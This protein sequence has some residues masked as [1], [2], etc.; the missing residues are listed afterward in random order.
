MRIVLPVHHFPP[1]YS[2]GA[3]LY[4]LRLARW[5]QSQGHDVEVVC[6]EA[7]DRG[8][9]TLSAAADTYDGITVWRLSFDM[10]ADPRLEYDNPLLG[11]WF[12]QYLDRR[13][14][15]LAHFQAGYL[16][17]AAPLE[18]AHAAGV[19][20]VL[21]LHDYWFLC[22]RITLLRGDGALCASVP[23][24][25]AECDWCMR[26]ASRRYRIADQLSAG[27]AGRA[28]MKLAGGP[29]RAQIADRRERLARALDLPDAVIAPSRFLAER[30]A[31]L[32]APERLVVSRLGL[33]PRPF[34]LLPQRPQGDGVLRIGYIGQ[35]APHKG[36]HL[37][38]EAF[39]RLR[40]VG[41]QIEL[42]IYGGLESNPAYVRWLRQLADGD[43][44]IQYH[45]RFENQRVAA[46]LARLDVMVTPSIWYENSP[47]TILESHAASVPVVTAALGGMAELVRHEVDGLHF[48]PA[49]AAD[50]ARQLQRA[51]DEPELLGRLRAGITP[52]RSL[53]D[54]GR[55]IESVYERL[56]A[57]SAGMLERVL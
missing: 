6:V 7:I 27:L 25:P 48:R 19:P 14:P 31:P 51:I 4:T 33:D 42:Q 45:G 2:A 50:L 35:I 53:D 52:P 34:Q 12:A 8:D 49:D 40:A 23:E 57:R 54:E 17:G 16:L 13:R 24:D 56:V 41:R 32:V 28:A 20:I 47:L 30:F 11:A 44:R 29:G 39:R 22:P 3:E 1:R 43:D 37:L 26:L 36:V 18:A 21:T 15:N 5:L 55:Q 46:I 38:V 10:R 9:G